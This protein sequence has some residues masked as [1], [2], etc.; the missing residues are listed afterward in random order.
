MSRTCIV[1][2]AVFVLTG[3]AAVKSGDALVQDALA[4]LPYKVESVEKRYDQFTVLAKTKGWEK[5]VPDI[6]IDSLGRTHTSYFEKG[7]VPTEYSEYYYGQP[8][9]M[10]WR[11]LIYNRKHHRVLCVDRIYIGEN[12]YA[13]IYIIQSGDK[14]YGVSVGY[15]N[16][17]G[18]ITADGNVYTLCAFLDK[19]TINTFNIVNSSTTNAEDAEFNDLVSKA[20]MS[21]CNEYYSE[22]DSF[23]TAALDIKNSVP[24]AILYQ[25]ACCAALNGKKDL[26]FA[27]LLEK[28]K[29]DKKWESSYLME[30]DP[31]LLT[32]H[33]DRRWNILLEII[34]FKSSDYEIVP[35]GAEDILY[36][37]ENYNKITKLAE[38]AFYSGDYSKAEKFLEIAV[39][40]KS[41]V[42]PACWYLYAVCASKTGKIDLAYERLYKYLRL[43]QK[44]ETLEHIIGN[45]DLENLHSDPRWKDI[46]TMYDYL[47][48]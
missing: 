10:I 29:T 41:Q 4:D 8:K 37:K 39:C 26:A 43:E 44:P 35:D 32:L 3:C 48:K 13:V 45:P 30:R 25:A 47:R 24:G 40:M 38:N 16:T 33:S 36:N 1:V 15:S 14:H 22:A 28:I 46:L 42:V 31:D 34:R 23:Y 5:W 19:Y 9:S 7:V 18:D 6:I 21:Y 20:N 27:R 11:N 2:F 17:H 12:S